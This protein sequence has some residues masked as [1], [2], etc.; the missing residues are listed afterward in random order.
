MTKADTTGG[1]KINGTD[2]AGGASNSALVENINAKS[3]ATGVSAAISSTNVNEV[4]YTA[5]A[6]NANTIKVNGVSVGLAAAATGAQAADAINNV[7]SQTGVTASFASGKLTLTSAGGADVSLA[8]DATNGVLG[9]INGGTSV[10]KSDAVLSAGIELSAKIGGTITVAA[11]ASGTTSADLNLTGTNAATAKTFKAS[12]IDISS[13]SGAN[14]AIKAADFALTQVN[15]SRAQLG[16][17]QNRF[18][19]V[20]ANLKSSSENLSAS[21]SRIQDTDFAAET[22][23]LSRNQILQQAG[24]AMLAQS[25]ALSNN[26]LSLLRG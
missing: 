8:D 19:A 4:A 12:T 6:T 14:D 20:V 25:N 13:V 2:I 16:A 9:A 26:V 18:S 22:A 1:F 15:S 21:R 5:D 7:S 11:G 24:T 3:T 17:V 10:N 23:N